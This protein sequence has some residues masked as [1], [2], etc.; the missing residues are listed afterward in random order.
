LFF[1]DGVRGMV[2]GDSVHSAIGERDHDGFAV[3]RRAQRRIHFAVRVVFADIF[4]EQGEVMR[5]NFAGHTGLGALAAT[6]GLERVRGGNVRHVQTRVPDLL[7]KRDVTVDNESF[8]GCRHAT[9][10]ETEAGGAGVHGA[11]FGD[12]GI[13]GVLHY[14]KVQLGPE[15]QSYT[16]DVIV[17]DGFGVIG[18]RHRTRAL[19]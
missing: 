19:Q 6:H 16:H 15:P 3:G 13:F 9:Q 7:R 2:G 10:T 18:N 5:R 1:V 8:R 12:A 11:V 17:E 4:V 14:G